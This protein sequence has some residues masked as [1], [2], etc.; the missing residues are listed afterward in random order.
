MPSIQEVKRVEIYQKLGFGRVLP[1][2]GRRAGL[3]DKLH[4][5]SILLRQQM[6]A[7]NSSGNAKTFARCERSETVGEDWD[8]T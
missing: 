6:E 8:S 3:K 7:T 1:I 2:P 4:K 5:S